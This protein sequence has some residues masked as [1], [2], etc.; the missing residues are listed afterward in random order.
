[1]RLYRYFETA[2]AFY[3]LLEYARGGRL[4]DHLSCYQRNKESHENLIRSVNRKFTDLEKSAFDENV[5]IDTANVT[6]VSQVG[7]TPLEKED[8]PGDKAMGCRTSYNS[9]SLTMQDREHSIKATHTAVEQLD[10][11]GNYSDHPRAPLSCNS[12]EVSA[13]RQ[14]LNK[15]KNTNDKHS[16]FVKLDEYFSSSA[17]S[18][19]D[20]HI[21]VWAAQLVLAVA[22][23]HTAGII[24]RYKIIIAELQQS[25]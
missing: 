3:L 20:E 24:C 11:K 4:W 18:V 13:A 14:D 8:T 5:T 17:Q 16:L 15:N 7:V 12:K 19:P 25:I 21:R 10:P 2:T 22:Y 23:L 6:T 1:M 9:D